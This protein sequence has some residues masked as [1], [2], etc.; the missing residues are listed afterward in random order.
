MSKT[1]DVPQADLI[2]DL[3]Y[4]AALA[5]L[6]ELLNELET[7]DLPLDDALTRYEEGVMLAARC[8]RLLEEAALRVRRW[9]GD[10]AP[11]DFADWE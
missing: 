10:E 8:E 3:T 2:A 4:E 9:Q 6:E 1:E 7:G 11:A 5:R